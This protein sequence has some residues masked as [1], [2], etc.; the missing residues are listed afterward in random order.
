MMVLGG[1]VVSYE[2]G[3][4]L[5]QELANLTACRWKKRVAGS[6]S[7]M[8]HQLNG[9]R[10]STSPP[11]RQLNYSQQQVDDLGK[12]VDFPKSKTLREIKLSHLGH[13]DGE[14]HGGA[15]GHAQRLVACDR[16]A[17][18]V[19]GAGCRVQGAGFR[20]QGSGFRVQGSG[21]RV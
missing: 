1:V 18:R 10:R 8:L 6:L 4:P 14:L 16:V 17:R 12:S 3:I 2:R 13:H 11:N 20:V 15:A 7:R 9:F 19:Q 5:D 21:C